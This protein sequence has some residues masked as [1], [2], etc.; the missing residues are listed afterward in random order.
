MLK[1]WLNRLEQAKR[2][3]ELVI[4]FQSVV[5]WL[6]GGVW[7]LGLGRRDAWNSD[8]A[9]HLKGS[10]THYSSFLTV[11]SP[12]NW[13]P[14]MWINGRRIL[15]WCSAQAITDF[16]MTLSFPSLRSRAWQSSTASAP[17]KS[18]T[19]VRVSECLSW[20]PHLHLSDCAGTYHSC[21]PQQALT[22]SALVTLRP[23]LSTN[24]AAW[25]PRLNSLSN[26]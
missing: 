22:P 7:G 13:N 9:K 14:S 26:L 18:K 10:T 6:W 4:N 19:W 23:F 16:Q 8:C 15:E 17:S 1:I 21:H 24:V 2:T 3:E 25:P 11:Y 5:L 12:K 20:L